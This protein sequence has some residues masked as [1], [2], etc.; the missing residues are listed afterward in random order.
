MASKKVS[1]LTALTTAGSDD[2]IYIADTSDSGSSYASKKI[3]VGNFLNGYATQS[4]VS[5]QISNL[6]DGAPSALNTLNEIAA[7][8]NDDSSIASTLTNLI[9]ANETHIDNVATLSGV[10]KDST[11]LGTFSGSTIADSST[12]KAALQALETSLETKG[13]AGSV[14]SVSTNVGDLVILS[15]VAQN[16]EDLGTFTGS[17]I[18]DNVTIKVAL[19]ALETALEA[20]DSLA[21][22]GVTS[23][24]AELNIL[25]GATSTAAELNLLDGV[26]ST[27]AELNILDGVTASAAEINLLDGVTATTTELNY[28]D[29]VTSAIQTQLNSKVATG[30]NVNT[31][32]GAT[33]AGTVPTDGN[34]DDNYLFL[35]VNKANGALVAIDKTFLEAEG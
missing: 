4:Y 12:L 20:S 24:A 27:T 30:A 2:L 23:T 10:A 28:V 9:N 3:T 31:L 18:A 7:A 8:I 32:V 21:D 35:V 16:A 25:D 15:G 6:I 33:S 19:Q 11:N 34:G 22:L 13:S 29:G 14:T 26:T 1:A 5:T 17:T